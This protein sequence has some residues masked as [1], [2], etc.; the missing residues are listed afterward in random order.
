MTSKT[1]TIDGRKFIVDFDENGE[2]LRIKERKTYE[3]GRPWERLYNASYWDA[4][5]HSLGG[6]DTLP[7]RII[8]AARV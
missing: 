6:P 1:V 4:K 3:A 8:A 2:P 5:H 7:V